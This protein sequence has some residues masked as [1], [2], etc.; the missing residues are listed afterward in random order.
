[1]GETS[2]PGRSGQQHRHGF[3]PVAGETRLLRL[4]AVAPPPRLGQRRQL[5]GPTAAAVGP[6]HAVPPAPLRRLPVGG[7][8]E[9]ARRRPGRRTP[10]QGVLVV[11][12]RRAAAVDRRRRRQKY[13]F[14]VVAWRLRST[15]L[16]QSS[17]D[18]RRHVANSISVHVSHL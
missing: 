10:H 15:A 14:V 9:R 11:D 7:A 3:Q 4:L 1:M 2:G 16:P 6:R 13:R 17:A 8:L 5:L 18:G 12:C